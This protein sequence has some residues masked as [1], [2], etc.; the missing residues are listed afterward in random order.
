MSEENE[1]V[2]DPVKEFAL[3]CE[4]LRSDENKTTSQYLAKKFNVPKL[5]QEFFQILFCI[6]QRADFVIEIIATLD[7]DADLVSEY[8]ENVNSIKNAFSPARLDSSWK[9]SSATHLSD[10]NIKTVKALSGLVRQKIKTPFLSEEDVQNV[11]ATTEELQSSLEKIQLSEKD[12]IRQAIID[13][14]KEFK[15]R[16]T[17]LSWVGWGYTIESLKEVISAYLILEG[18]APSSQEQPDMMVVLKKS[19]AGLKAIFEGMKIAK[20]ISETAGYFLKVYGTLTLIGTN[21]P[22]IS[23]LL[24]NL[25]Q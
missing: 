4:S 1:N 23:G 12:F 18:L 6:L 19:G 2:T 24:S 3:L 25:K 8:I 15:F 11:M 20:D 9:T 14:I 17:H 5:S 10:V 22:T 13:G 21:L 16:L 7:M